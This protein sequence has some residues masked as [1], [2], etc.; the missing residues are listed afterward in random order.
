MENACEILN[1]VNHDISYISPPWMRSQIQS[2]L[3]KLQNHSEA[4]EK[5]REIRS[6]NFKRSNEDAELYGTDGEPIEF[7]WSH[8]D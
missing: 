4:N 8:N 5:W 6:V 1:F 7:E 3:R 2:C